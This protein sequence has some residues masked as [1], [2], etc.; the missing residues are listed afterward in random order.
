MATPYLPL[1]VV[2]GTLEELRSAL[3]RDKQ[4]RKAAVCVFFEKGSSAS[5]LQLACFFGRFDMATALVQVYSPPPPAPSYLL[6]LPVL[7]R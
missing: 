7:H 1:I 4:K 6:L 3:P 5:L 2:E